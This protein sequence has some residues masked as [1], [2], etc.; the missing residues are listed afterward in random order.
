MPG[1]HIS[2]TDEEYNLIPKPKSTW[3]RELVLE[4]I[5]NLPDEKVTVADAVAKPEVEFFFRVDGKVFS[6]TGRSPAEAA[7][8]LG[9]EGILDW[10]S[11]R[12]AEKEGWLVKT[13]PL[14]V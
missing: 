14:D 12:E 7:R 1:M 6:G 9:I 2:F 5:K 8:K 3:V 4:M 13:D 11:K 10:R